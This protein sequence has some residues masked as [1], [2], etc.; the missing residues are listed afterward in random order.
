M[1][2]ATQVPPRLAFWCR[3]RGF[4]P[5]RPPFPGRSP[6]FLLR[7]AGGPT[8]PRARRHA[9]GLGFCAFAR[10][11]LRNHFC[12]LLLR[13]M[14]CF[15]SP[16]SPRTLCG[17]AVPCGGLPHSDIRGSTG[18]C[19]SPRL[20]AACHVLLRLREPRH[21]SCALLSFPCSFAFEPKSN[22]FD[23]TGL[24]PVYRTRPVSSFCFTR[25][26]FPRPDFFRPSASIMSMSSLLFRSPWQS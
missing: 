10:H 4:H 8:T 20:F 3:V 5:L 25:F 1:S 15:S 17:A 12:F 7:F 9:R 19:P 2:C 26:L 23:H 6:T 22:R 14:R 21:P 11:Y 16:G 18:I 24:R 13:V